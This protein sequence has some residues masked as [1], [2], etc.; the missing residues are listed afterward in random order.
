MEE[1]A[2]E[3]AGNKGEE[4]EEKEEERGKKEA[5]AHTDECW[6]D[7]TWRARHAS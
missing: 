1:A 5:L 4:E 7:T 6:E 2:R 3:G